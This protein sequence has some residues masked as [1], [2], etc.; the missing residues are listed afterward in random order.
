MTEIRISRSH[1]LPHATARREAQKIA[2]QLKETFDLE[3]EWQGDVVHFQRLGVTGC[4]RVGET[5]ILLEAKLGVLLAF[6]GPTI[7]SHITENLERVF[8]NDAGSTR[9]ARP[10]PRKDKAR[11]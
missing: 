7:E 3:Y 4:L 5:D 10:G 9:P 2:E 1:V 8:G 11:R 6:L